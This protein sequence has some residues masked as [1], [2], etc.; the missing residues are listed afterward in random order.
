MMNI[1]HKNLSDDIFRVILKFNFEFEHIHID[2]ITYEY[3]FIYINISQSCLLST[4]FPRATYGRLVEY[5]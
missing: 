1:V 4:D 2:L 3:I 5:S